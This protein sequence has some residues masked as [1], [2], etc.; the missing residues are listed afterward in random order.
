[1]KSTLNGRPAYDKEK[2]KPVNT[3]VAKSEEKK[4]QVEWDE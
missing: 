4:Y 3:V 1:L 2:E